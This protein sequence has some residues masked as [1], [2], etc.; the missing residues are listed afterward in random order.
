[1][2][3]FLLQDKKISG[4][5]LVSR[6][7][8]FIFVSFEN[9]LMYPYTAERRDVLSPQQHPQQPADFLRAK[10]KGNL[11]GERHLEVV[12]LCTTQFRNLLPLFS[13][14]HLRP[15][16]VYFISLF[17]DK[18]MASNVRPF[19]RKRAEN[20]CGGL[21]LPEANSYQLK[22]SLIHP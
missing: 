16:L 11:D 12:G 1:M 18:Q 13:S 17:R 7:K 10:P 20:L 4:R 9:L 5:R 19:P 8:V 15:N 22:V 6:P 2:Q 21:I 14:S 3:Q